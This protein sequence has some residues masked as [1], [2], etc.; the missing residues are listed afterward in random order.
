MSAAAAPVR[1]FDFTTRDF[2][3]AQ[4][5]IHA[6]A[7]ICLSEAKQEMVY[8]RLARRLRETGE[9]S[10]SRYLIK[11]FS[12]VNKPQTPRNLCSGLKRFANNVATTSAVL[13]QP[14]TRLKH[15]LDFL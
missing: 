14:K 10:F 15:E 3:R 5:L 12:L 7:G 8:S 9:T 4:A 1:E 6:H 11:C 2:E 13:S